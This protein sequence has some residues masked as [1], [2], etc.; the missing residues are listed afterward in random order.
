MPL[1]WDDEEEDLTEIEYRPSK[2][3]TPSTPTSRT[4]AEDLQLEKT[5]PPR[6][7][8]APILTKQPTAT[9]KSQA[10]E[11]LPAAPRDRFAAFFLDTYFGLFLYLLVGWILSRLFGVENLSILHSNSTRLILHWLF[12]GILFFFYYLLMEASLGATLGKLI[13]GLRVLEVNGQSPSLGSIV[14]RNCLRLI[15]YPFAFLVATLSMESS[16]LNQRLGDKAANTLVIKKAR[17]ARP[18]VDLKHTPLASTFSRLLA[19]IIDL[20]LVLAALYG[21]FRWINFQHPFQSA[22]IILSLPLLF[23]AY[24]SLTEGLMGSSPGKFLFKRQVVSGHGQKVDGSAAVLRNLFRPL[25]YLLGYPL[26]ILSKQ[27]QRLGDMAAD[28]LVMA[29]GIGKK[30]A[31]GSLITFALVALIFFIGLKNKTA[32][33]LSLLKQPTIMLH[34]L[35]PQV[36]KSNTPSPAAPLRGVTPRPTSP[37]SNQTPLPPSTSKQLKLV[38]FYFAT[39]P[40]PTQIRHNRQFRPGDLV[41]LFFKVEGFSQSAAQEVSLKQDLKIEDPKGRVILEEEDAHTIAKK[42]SENE[43]SMLFANHFQL[44]QEALKGKYRVIITVHDDI[45]DKQFSFEKKFNVQ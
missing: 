23:I 29:K 40:E 13:C 24:Y 38:E 39:G 34:R 9:Q 6:V 8:T 16:P 22:L 1:S 27:K 3:R 28:T 25:D 45:A 17:P 32:P 44:N 37:I 35:W 11:L 31:Y 7:V 4:I 10:W 19:E 5:R 21:L 30:G 41:Y 42:L 2:I 12:S 43:K 20:T 26:I 18:T 14:I 36:N 15:D 33:K